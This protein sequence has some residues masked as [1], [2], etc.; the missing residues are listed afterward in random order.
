MSRTRLRRVLGGAAS[1]GPVACAI[2]WVT[3]PLTWTG[4]NPWRQDLS[5]LST[6]AAP[7]P[8]ITVSG[9]LL[10]SVGILGLA[11]GLA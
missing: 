4:Y 6:L 1:A 11:T 8:W 10:L 3:A 7:W 5:T 2:A 9:E